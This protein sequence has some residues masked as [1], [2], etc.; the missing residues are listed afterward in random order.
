MRL[1][2]PPWLM[3]LLLA[4]A[5]G[6]LLSGS[7]P[8]VEYFQPFGF[9]VMTVLYGCGALL[10]RELKVRWRKGVGSLVLLG[11]AYGVIEEGL[12]VASFFNPGWMDL[13]ALEG[14]G[15]WLGVNWVW[16]VELTMYHAFFSVTVPVLLVELAY[17]KKKPKLWL[18]D[19]QLKIAAAALTLDVVGGFFLFGNLL[20]YFPTAPQYVL[21]V[22]VAVLFIYA[23]KRLPSDWLRRGVKPM[24]RPYFYTALSFVTAVLS[25]VVFGVLP[26][27]TDAALWPLAV[28]MIGVAL[29]WTVVRLLRGYDWREAM[30]T[31]VMGLASG[32]VILFIL[33]TPI[34][35]LD[36]SRTDDTTGMMIVGAAFLLGLTL[37]ARR[38]SRNNTRIAGL[39]SDGDSI[40][41]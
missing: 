21:M 2:F 34:Q 28:S 18:T 31:H 5:M 7:S 39:P 23:A 14:F 33:T 22:A 25:A 27:I 13:G 20:N 17:Q 24:R 3:L 6:E 40:E 38:V 12:M 4:P 35:E 8:P 26:S 1:R 29:V 11:C 32:P 9:T 10:C 36:V 19:T 30:R 37:L 41:V 15:R 16:A